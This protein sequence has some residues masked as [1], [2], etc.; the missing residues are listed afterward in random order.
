MLR[1]ADSVQ[2]LTCRIRADALPQVVS[3]YAL[4]QAGK[5]APGED[6]V[7]QPVAGEQDLGLTP[8]L[9]QVPK[10]LPQQAPT[11]AGS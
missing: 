10:P 5:A 4:Q 8:T 3:V 9:F 6:D 1:Q 2:C 7:I 11:N